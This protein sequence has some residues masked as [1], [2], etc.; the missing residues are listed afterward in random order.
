MKSEL[1]CFKSLYMSI[2]G[3]EGITINWKRTSSVSSENP[4]NR[5]TAVTHSNT[6]ERS[7]VIRDLNVGR[8]CSKRE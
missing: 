7:K 4:A 2:S 6:S 5:G 3:T 1:Y 8:I